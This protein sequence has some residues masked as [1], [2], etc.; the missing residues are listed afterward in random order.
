M[1]VHV[2][3]IIAAH[4]IKG[5]VKVKSF[6]SDPK[7]FATYGPLLS[8]DGRVFEI[9][10]VRPQKDEFLCTL[11]NVTDRNAA[12]ALRGV[13]LCVAREK[14]PNL[15][16]GEFYLQDLLGK[17]VEAEGKIIGTVS[18]FQ[19]FGAGDL[20]ELHDGML[21]PMGFV[22]SVGGIVKMDLPAGYLD[23]AESP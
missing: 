13:E 21:L 5:E 3:T 15:A 12:E 1:F 16:E 23:K 2:A 9:K 11:S 4:G 14:L 8:K 17:M 20:I 7:A 18:G 6:T 19:N 22:V 10:T